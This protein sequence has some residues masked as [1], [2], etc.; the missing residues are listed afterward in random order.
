MDAFVQQLEAHLRSHSLLPGDGRLVVAVSGGLDSMMLLHGLHGLVDSLRLRL[1][2]AHANHQLRGRESAGDARSVARTAARLGL[3]CIQARLPV[4]AARAASGDSLEMAARSLRHQFLA[5]VAV[6]RGISTVAVA[7]QADD[8]AELV[9]LRLIRGAGSDGLGAMSWSNPSP[10]NPAVRLI[11]P[12]LGFTRKALEEIARSRG[13]RHRED[14]SNRDPGILRNRIRTELL[15]LLEREYSPAIRSLLVRTADVLGAE[16]ELV[17]TEAERWLQAEK[18]P[19]FDTLPT[20]LQRAVLRIQMVRAGHPVGFEPIERLRT[21]GSVEEVAPGIRFQ[22]DPSGRLRRRTAND[23]P[24]FDD[25]AQWLALAAPSGSATVAGTRVQYRL[26][27]SRPRRSGHAASAAEAFDADA[28]GDWVLLRHWQPG[29]RFQPLGFPRPSKL[30]NLLV[31][32]K[33]PAARRRQLLV[34]ATR[35]GVVFWVE[36]LPPGEAFKVTAAS[37]HVLLWKWRALA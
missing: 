23:L 3:P 33:V 18:P 37:R 9:L 20:A 8:R 10:A 27:R 35:D 28:V 31:N 1:V 5:D 25:N 6:A 36:S 4:A 7:H 21:A 34:A 14:A 30:Q 13:I 17:Q 22:R 29:D 15:P 19:P 11:R 32:R 26:A 12:L 24:A 2:V 16:A